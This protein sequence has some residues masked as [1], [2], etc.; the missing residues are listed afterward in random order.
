MISQSQGKGKGEQLVKEDH[1]RRIAPRTRSERIL[2]C[3]VGFHPDAM[4]SPVLVVETRNGVV[5]RIRR[6]EKERER[7]REKVPGGARMFWKNPSFS[8][9]RA[10]QLLL[11][12]NWI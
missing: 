7:K 8:D 5:V 3:S 12:L 10:T 1:P 4:R 6:A 9:K 2:T 11:L